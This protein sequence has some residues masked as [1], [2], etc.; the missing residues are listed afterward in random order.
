MLDLLGQMQMLDLSG[1][2][3][4]L[5]LSGQMQMLLSRPH[6][7]GLGG[8]DDGCRYCIMSYATGL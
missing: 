1:Q 7:P 4:M 6:W 2:M 5:D 8:T 3:Q